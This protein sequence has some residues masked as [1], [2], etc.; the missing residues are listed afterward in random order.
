MNL[1]VALQW[2]KL[3]DTEVRLL[4]DTRTNRIV[5]LI[6]NTQLLNRNE[7]TSTLILTW[8][9]TNGKATSPP[10]WKEQHLWVLPPDFGKFYSTMNVSLA[11]ST[12]MPPRHHSLLSWWLI[13]E[14]PSEWWRHPSSSIILRPSYK[15]EA[16]R[17]IF[18]VWRFG[19]SWLCTGVCIIG[20]SLKVY[21]S[22]KA[23][24]EFYNKLG[25]KNKIKKN[26]NW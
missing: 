6:G 3:K 22:K 7:A 11:G 5:F 23:T 12:K 8:K 25:V 24:F 10:V 13:L 9:G 14:D 2:T 17:F 16:G 1:P 18:W 21:I 19:C 4:Y 15:E 20:G 26:V